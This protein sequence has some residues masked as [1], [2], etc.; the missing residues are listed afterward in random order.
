MIQSKIETLLEGRVVEHDRIEYK[1]G[2]NPNDIIHSIC[3]FANDF[4]NTNGGYIVIGVEEED[5]IPVFPFVGIPRKNWIL[6]SRKYFS[7][8]IRLFHAI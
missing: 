8:A 1:T 2:W 3:A 7:I 5:G 4:D 6:F